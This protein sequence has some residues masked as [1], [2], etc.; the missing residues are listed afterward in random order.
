MPKYLEMTTPEPLATLPTSSSF[1]CMNGTGDVYLPLKLCKCITK[2]L[3]DHLIAALNHYF[4]HNILFRDQLRLCDAAN[5]EEMSE[6]D[7][8][9]C[10]S[11][12]R[13]AI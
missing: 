1:Y 6:S 5:T 4:K 13:E 11:D 7:L 9:W 8:D 2:R 12:T 3:L 10:D